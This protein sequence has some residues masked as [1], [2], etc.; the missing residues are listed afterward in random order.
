MVA[1]APCVEPEEKVALLSHLA[2]ILT[3]S[4]T[5]MR[6]TRRPSATV[7]IAAAG[8]DHGASASSSFS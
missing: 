4:A 3:A 2:M 6:S 5:M 7:P 1:C 8:A